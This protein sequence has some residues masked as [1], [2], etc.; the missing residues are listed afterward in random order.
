MSM[1]PVGNAVVATMPRIVDGITAPETGSFYQHVIIYAYAFD[2]VV[3]HFESK[4]WVKIMFTWLQRRQFYRNEM[5]K[6]RDRSHPIRLG[7]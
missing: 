7:C 3:R 6:N 1:L 2:V 4:M 5:D